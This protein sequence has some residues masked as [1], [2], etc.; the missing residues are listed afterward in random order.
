MLNTP[1]CGTDALLEW[2]TPG[3]DLLEMETLSRRSF[4]FSDGLL[5]EGSGPTLYLLSDP[6]Q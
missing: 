3:S 6:V 4:P 5:K 2:K 1:F